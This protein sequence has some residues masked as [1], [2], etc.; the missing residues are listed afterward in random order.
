MKFYLL[1][2]EQRDDFVVLSVEDQNGTGYVPN[3]TL[4]LENVIILSHRLD[5]EPV[6]DRKHVTHGTIDL[7]DSTNKNFEVAPASP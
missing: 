7:M 3:V 6:K 1:C 2:K 5:E 4:A